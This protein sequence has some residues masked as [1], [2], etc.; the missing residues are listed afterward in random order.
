MG[1]GTGGGTFC[2]LWWRQ[3]NLRSLEFFEVLFVWKWEKS[4]SAWYLAGFELPSMC[5]D[6]NFPRVLPQMRWRQVELKAFVLYRV[7]AR[8]KYSWPLSSWVCVKVV[9]SSKKKKKFQSQDKNLTT[10]SKPPRKMVAHQPN[11]A[12]SYTHESSLTCRNTTFGYHWSC[13]FYQY[14]TVILYGA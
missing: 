6:W 11:T 5:G 3:W 2:K 7:C 4:F 10:L 9:I 8:K 13:T 1:G 14:R 12:A